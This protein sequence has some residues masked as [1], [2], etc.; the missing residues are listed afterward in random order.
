MIYDWTRLLPQSATGQ[1]TLQNLKHNLFIWEVV[2]THVAR[3]PKYPETFR[4]R[5]DGVFT[6]SGR[7]INLSRKFKPEML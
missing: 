4:R 7:N 2:K 3:S 1:S 6:L 5:G